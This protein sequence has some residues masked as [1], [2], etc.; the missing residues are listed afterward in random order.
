M[1]VS[2]D[3]HMKDLKNEMSLQENRI[4]RYQETLARLRIGYY[5][6]LILQDSYAYKLEAEIQ[7]LKSMAAAEL[8]E[9]PVIRNGPKVLL[10]AKLSEDD[11][12]VRNVIYFDSTDGLDLSDDVIQL[13]NS[14]IEKIVK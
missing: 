12:N 2:L 8:G 9:G 11:K 10:N 6:E 14:K 3:H 5:K 1:V 7:G 13:L 4:K